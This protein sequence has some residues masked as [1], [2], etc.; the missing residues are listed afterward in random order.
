MEIPAVLTLE[1]LAV[2]QR[3]G[4]DIDAWARTSGPGDASG[5][6]DQDWIQVDELRH[7]LCPTNPR[8]PADDLQI[9]LGLLMVVLVACGSRSR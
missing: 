2:Y 5:M 3:F 4:G 8:A 7:A 6:T 1:K 9:A